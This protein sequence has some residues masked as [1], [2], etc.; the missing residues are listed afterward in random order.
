MEDANATAPEAANDTP[1]AR[2]AAKAAEA[3]AKFLNRS[4]PGDKA[5]PAK[6]TAAKA[7]ANKTAAK[8]PA[9]KAAP[10]ARTSAPAKTAASAPPAAAEPQPAPAAPRRTPPPAEQEK[11][12][13]YSARINLTT[14][15]AQKKALKLAGVEDGIDTTARIRAMIAL[16]E[17]DERLRKRIDK[18]AQHWR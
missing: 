2:R 12:T 18:A 13:F 6:K 10:A 4:K 5:A 15:E 17:E 3:A 9:K 14:T 16:W 8:A 11:V 1:Q 7:P